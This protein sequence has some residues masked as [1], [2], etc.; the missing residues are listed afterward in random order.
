MKLNW[1]EIKL[2]DT[3]SRDLFGTAILL[4]SLFPDMFLEDNLIQILKGG[5]A[6][7]INATTINFSETDIVINGH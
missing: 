7:T 1:I 3:K 4:L 5:N 2:K 6:T